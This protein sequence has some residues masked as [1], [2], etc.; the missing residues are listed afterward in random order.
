M[1]AAHITAKIGLFQVVSA[2]LR[3]H[4]VL[5]TRRRDG[6]SQPPTTGQGTTL[7]GRIQSLCGNTAHNAA[8]RTAFTEPRRCTLRVYAIATVHPAIGSVTKM[9]FV[10]RLSTT[11]ANTTTVARVTATATAMKS[12][13]ATWCAEKRTVI[14]AVIPVLFLPPIAVSAQTA[15][16]QLHALPTRVQFFPAQQPRH[17]QRTAQQRS[18]LP[19]TVPRPP[20]APKQLVVT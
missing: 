13:W 4:M 7:S 18:H 6:A 3:A 17:L 19:R 20:F 15:P 8:P 16:A 1:L 10:V 2:K 11:T 9:G 5:G 12:A 14:L